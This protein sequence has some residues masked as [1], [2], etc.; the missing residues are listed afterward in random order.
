MS[1]RTVP[2]VERTGAPGAGLDTARH[3]GN[4]FVGTRA[5]VRLALRRDRIMLPAWILVFVT[6]A[7]SSAA[8]TVDLYPTVESRT[9]FAASANSNPSLLAMYGWVF[10]GTS[11]GAVSMYKT[12]AFGAA[13]VAILAM[14]VTVRHTRAE[15]EAGRLEL[16]GA[17]VVGRYAALAAALI[18]SAGTSVVLGLLTAV[19]LMAAELPASG[20]FAFGLTWAAVGI[21][22]AMVG[23]VTAQL[24]TSARSANGLS[25]TAL[26]AAY[27]LRAVG[28][29][30]GDGGPTWLSWLSPIGWG[31]QVRPYAG[32][33]WWVFLIFIASWVAA[34]GLVYLL[35][36]R[37]DMGSGVL[38]DRP[39]PARASAGLRSPLAL[40]WRLHRNALLGWTAGFT[41]LG[42][43]LGGVAANVGDMLGSDQA[44]ELIEQL[45]GKQALSDAFLAAEMGFVGAFASAFGIQAAM[46][47]RTEEVELRAEPLLATAVG[48]IR[49][50]AS[51]I[52]VALVG[53]AVLLAAAGAAAGLV[54][55]AQTDTGQFGRVLG[56]AVAYLPAVWVLTGIVVAVFGLAPTLIVAGWVALAAF[57]LIGQFGPI[58]QLDQLV[59]D[60]SPFTHIPRLGFEFSATPLVLLTAVAATLIGVGLSAFR[61]RDSC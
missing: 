6:V 32:D 24:T 22:F 31:Q 37:R 59:M 30:T 8:T 7:A 11:L 9:Q 14:L 54:H 46:R 26:G 20:S 36:S 55:A 23:A 13:M 2:T 18:V 50:A 16:V 57:L 3:G 27:L 44:R 56:H 48:R 41:L 45:G 43:V 49:W 28:D 52:M 1:N 29:S 19:S 21:T 35:V 38:A 40:A 17:T 10:D 42:L 47:L 4:A 34:C 12:I 33:R 39:G 58:F 53:S 25:A 60:L 61:R 5:L 15:E 51:H